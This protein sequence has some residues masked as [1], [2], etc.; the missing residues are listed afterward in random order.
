MRGDAGG[1]AKRDADHQAGVRF[2]TTRG[3]HAPARQSYREA[4]RNTAADANRQ[5]GV[6]FVGWSSLYD[7]TQTDSGRVSFFPPGHLAGLENV[8]SRRSMKI[9]KQ[10][11]GFELFEMSMTR[12]ALLLEG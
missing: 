12:L 3:S 2:T 9:V 1:V 8:F 7:I 4:G 11:N 10:A 5:A 6:H